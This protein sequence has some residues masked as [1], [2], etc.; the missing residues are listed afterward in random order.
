MVPYSKKFFWWIFDLTNFFIH[1][2]TC[3]R[4]FQEITLNFTTNHCLLWYNVSIF[5]GEISPWEKTDEYLNSVAEHVYEQTTEISFMASQILK[6]MEDKIYKT[7][8]MQH[9]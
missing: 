7:H 9:R 5:E 2:P 8:I 3:L 4:E 6:K 1:F